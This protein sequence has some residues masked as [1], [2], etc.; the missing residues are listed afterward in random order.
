MKPTDNAEEEEK[1][2]LDRCREAWTDEE[3]SIQNPSGKRFSN[4]NRN[5]L[6]LVNYKF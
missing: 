2:F 4:F 3:E 5:T 1:Y 6:K